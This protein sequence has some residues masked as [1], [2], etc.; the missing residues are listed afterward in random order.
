M[1]IHKNYTDKTD[2]HTYKIHKGYFAIVSA[3][4]TQTQLIVTLDT[5]NAAYVPKNTQ[6]TQ[7]AD[8][9]SDPLLCLWVYKF[10]GT[11]KSSNLITF[12]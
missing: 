1:Q 9:Y 8:I 3:H 11:N 4:K 10:R 12:P 2:I 5:Q 6:C 7:N